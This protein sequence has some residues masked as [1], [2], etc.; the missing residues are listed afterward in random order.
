VTTPY[1][2][3]L[4]EKFGTTCYQL[5]TTYEAFYRVGAALPA[6]TFAAGT[7]MTDP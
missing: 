3:A 2:G 4:Y 1:T 6:S 7:R 5:T